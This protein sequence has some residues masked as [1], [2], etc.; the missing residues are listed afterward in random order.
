MYDGENIIFI[1]LA[2]NGFKLQLVVV[3]VLLAMKYYDVV[4]LS[5]GNRS[6]ILIGWTNKITLKNIYGWWH[7]SELSN[8]SLIITGAEVVST[9]CTAS[10]HRKWIKK[11]HY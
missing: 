2:P 8:K 10:F 1:A 7:N 4:F 6:F 11:L 9:L 5:T 3:L